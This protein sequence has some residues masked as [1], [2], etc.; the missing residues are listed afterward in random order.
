MKRPGRSELRIWNDI[1]VHVR[2]LRVSGATLAVVVVGQNGRL[3]RP[4]GTKRAKKVPISSDSVNSPGAFGPR[5]SL[6]C[7]T[8]TRARAGEANYREGR[9]EPLKAVWALSPT[10]RRPLGRGTSGALCAPPRP[11]SPAGG[12]GDGTLACPHHVREAAASSRRPPFGPQRARPSLVTPSRTWTGAAQHGPGPLP[13]LPPLLTT[14]AAAYCGF[15]TTGAIRKARIEWRL[16]PVG[17]RGGRGTWMWSSEEL[18]QFF[19]ESALLRSDRIVRVRLLTELHMDKKWIKRW[20]TWVAPTK[21]PGVWMHQKGGY[22][23]RAHHRPDHGLQEGDP[24]GPP[25][26]SC[27]R[28]YASVAATRLPR[29]LPP[30]Y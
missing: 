30:T 9:L 15:K 16:T 13:S 22:L 20:K 26:P 23:V 8:R 1:E 19:E 29:P 25:S 14:R 7:P 3:F 24:Q 17:K 11:A 18:D 6:T 4:D 10:G 27:G 2:L 5:D 12:G 28:G 21:L